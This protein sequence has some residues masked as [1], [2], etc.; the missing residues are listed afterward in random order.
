MWPCRFKVHFRLE[1][2]A[3]LVSFQLSAKGHRKKKKGRGGNRKMM[4]MMGK[5]Q[6]PYSMMKGGIKLCEITNGMENGNRESLFIVSA[7]GRIR[8]QVKLT[9]VKLKPNKSRWFF[10]C[11]KLKTLYYRVLW[12]LKCTWVWQARR[13]SARKFSER[14]FYRDKTSDQKFPVTQCREVLMYAY[15]VLVLLCISTISCL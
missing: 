3:V 7:N 4:K 10:K 12:V 5:E 1:Y 13:S 6:L 2:S 11:S 14:L 9:D 15:E 8:G